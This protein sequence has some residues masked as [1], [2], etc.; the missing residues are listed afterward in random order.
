MVRLRWSIAAVAATSCAAALHVGPARA[1]L[2]CEISATK[3]GFAAV[4]AAPTRNAGIVKKHP[5]NQLILLD[6]TRKPPASAKDWLAVSIEDA[7][8]KRIVGRGWVHK[9]LIKADSCG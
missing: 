5:Q 6:D 4:R 2:Y 1:S 8:S 7:S 9:S 3:D